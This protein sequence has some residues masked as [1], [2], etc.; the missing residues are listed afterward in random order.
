[1]VEENDP[2][3]LFDDLP[4]TEMGWEVYPE[5]LYQLLCRLH[6]EYQVPKLYITENGASYSSAPGADGKVD[7]Q[8][9]LDYLRQ[10][11]IAT[12]RAIEAGAPV[13]GYFAWSFMDN[14]EWAK[15]YLQR[16]GIVWVNYETQQRIPKESALWYSQVIEEN[17]V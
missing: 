10:H 17:G 12:H 8:E 6:F 15:G 7:D 5:G 11:F 3:T 16:F 14:F 13:A 1:M 4:K 9:R 2:Q